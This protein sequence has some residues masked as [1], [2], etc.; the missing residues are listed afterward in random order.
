MFYYALED[1]GL[2]LFTVSLCVFLLDDTTNSHHLTV[3]LQLVI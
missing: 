1:Y 2:Q 3:T